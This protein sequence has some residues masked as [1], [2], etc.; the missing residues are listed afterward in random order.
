MDGWHLTCETSSYAH[1]C[2]AA[3]QHAGFTPMDLGIARDAHSGLKAAL[4]AA[5]A[6][7]HVLITSGGVSMGACA[8]HFTTSL[9]PL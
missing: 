1:I 9:S 4:D 8:P 3:V 5:L 7:A 2:N 6:T